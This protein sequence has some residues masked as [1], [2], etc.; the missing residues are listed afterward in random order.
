MNVSK[1]PPPGP[2][3]LQ[4]I[5]TPSGKYAGYENFPV[6][7]WL[8]PKNLRPHIMTFYR[9]ARAIDDIADSPS[10]SPEEK[11]KR[12]DGFADALEKGAAADG[13]GKAVGMADSLSRTGVTKRHCLDLIAA[14]RQDATKNRYAT[15][16]DLMAY[17][18]LSA[19]PVGRYLIDL[20]GGFRNAPDNGYKAA[21]ALCC[22][23]QVINHLQDCSDD[24]RTLDRMYL[25]Q[26]WMAEEGAGAAMLA[27]RSTSSELRRVLDRMLGATERLLDDSR[28]L[29]L[30]LRSS[31]LSMEA[32]FIQRIAEQLCRKLRTNDPLQA[33]VTL[34]RLKYLQC[35]IMGVLDCVFKRA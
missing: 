24:F 34:G 25:P 2:D 11:L 17:C 27:A 18:L 15:W 33:R 35:G 8:L 21:D 1:P 6:G 31:R 26:D 3:K 7:S 23:L 29:P 13:Y 32:A 5:E 14:F 4:A 22:A 30:Q 19:A 12:L 28:A 10:L 20:H 9:Y 16:E